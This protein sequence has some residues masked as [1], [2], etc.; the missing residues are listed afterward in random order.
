LHADS[1]PSHRFPAI[2]VSTTHMKPSK[3]SIRK[4]GN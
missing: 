4:L 2:Q 1:V 3:P